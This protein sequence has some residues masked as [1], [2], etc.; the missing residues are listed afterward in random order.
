VLVNDT[1]ADERFH[2]HMDALSG[3][4]TK[5]A[6]VVPLRAGGVV[7]GAL[8]ALNKPG[9]FTHSDVERLGLAAAYAASAIEDQRL[10]EEAET[11]RLMIHELE[12][13]RDVQSKL[14][15][16]DLPP[17][18]GLEYTGFCRPAKFVGGDYYDFIPLP[19]GLFAFTLGDVS[20]KGIAAAVL[21]ANIQAVLRSLL[22]REPL[23]LSLLM[24]HLNDAVYRASTAERYT[25]LFCGVLNAERTRLW[26]VNAGQVPP[27]V[28]RGRGAEKH[29][30]RPDEG[31]MP[32]GLIDAA[33]YEQG[34]M[35]LAPGDLV[36]CFSD[37]IT[38]AENAQ[39]KLWDDSE[40]KKIARE[41][42]DEPVAGLVERIVQATDQFA[43]G[44]EQADDM[45]VIALRVG[46]LF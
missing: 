20:G 34:E 12:I 22:S 39:G 3:Y 5:S 9:G 29:M 2:V 44:A 27:I 16:Q 40:V 10:R 6:L 42:S 21:M 45:T 36:L 35:E 31:G 46:M 13:A 33:E 25:T 38:E 1:A 28:L 19:E 15:P 26:Y 4:T 30:T 8:Q 7:I 37:G 14:L 17:V 11:A 18:A 24:N 41:H 32:V 43:A 23:P